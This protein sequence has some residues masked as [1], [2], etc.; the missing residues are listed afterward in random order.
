MGRGHRARMPAATSV[1]QGV[2]N[3]WL[4]NSCGAR[5]WSPYWLPVA[6]APGAAGARGTLGARGA[7]AHPARPA[8]LGLQSLVHLEPNAASAAFLREMLTP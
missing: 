8:R 6:G 4:S 3:C 1:R 5:G 7:H 2:R